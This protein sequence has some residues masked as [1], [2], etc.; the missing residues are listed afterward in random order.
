M[1]EMIRENVARIKTTFTLFILS[2]D[3]ECTLQ[4]AEVSNPTKLPMA[5][6]N[7]ACDNGCIKMPAVRLGGKEQM[8]K[9]QLARCDYYENPWSLWS[10]G[11]I[12][13]GGPR[14]F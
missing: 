4:K 2:H 12:F 5:V 6:P 11:R 8:S 9:Y 1:N 3:K 13:F 14:I 10:S 7:E